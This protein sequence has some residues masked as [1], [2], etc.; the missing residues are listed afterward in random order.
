VRQKKAKRNITPI[1]W[2]MQKLAEGKY[3]SHP[4]VSD[5]PGDSVVEC[6]KQGLLK[7][8]RSYRLRCVLC[9]YE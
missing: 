9:M 6:K 4:D 3:S 1:H 5:L 8:Y 7:S 2:F